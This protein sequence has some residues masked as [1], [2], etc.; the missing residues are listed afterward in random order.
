MGLFYKEDLIT[1]EYLESKGFKLTIRKNEVVYK[2]K[3]VASYGYGYSS[4]NSYYYY[5]PKTQCDVENILHEI[6]RLEVNYFDKQ[7]HNINDSFVLNN[8]KTQ[9]DMDMVIQQCFDI[10]KKKCK[11]AVKISVENPQ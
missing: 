3:I 5:F 6:S 2:L 1:K 9:F 11:Q 8:P 4:H 7:Y 10:V